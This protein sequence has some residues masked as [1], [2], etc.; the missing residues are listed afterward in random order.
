MLGLEKLKPVHKVTALT[1][2][3]SIVLIFAF[4]SFFYVN[5][6]SGY[7]SDILNG[8]YDRYLQLNRSGLDGDRGQPVVVDFDDATMRSLGDPVLVPPQAEALV[9]QRLAAQRPRLVF[10]DLDLTYLSGDEA[11]IVG[12]ALSQLAESGIPVLLARDVL[13]DTNGANGRYRASPLDALVAASPN[14]TWVTP[15]LWADE[16]DGVTRHFHVVSSAALHGR[17]TVLPSPALAVLL[18]D[19]TGSLPAAERAFADGLAGRATCMP[20]RA[21]PRWLVICTGRGNAAIDMQS[22]ARIAYRFGWDPGEALPAQTLLRH[23]DRFD[24]TVLRDRIVV[25]GSSA[26]GRDFA[27]TPLKRMPGLMIHANAMHA[28][29]TSRPDRGLSFWWGA[30]FVVPFATAVALFMVV[31][32]RWTPERFRS[33]LRTAIPFI[34]TMI[35]WAIFQL[36]DAPAIAVGLFPVAFMLFAVIALAERWFE[37]LFIPPP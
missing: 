15:M 13:P 35:F 27:H 2:L 21:P 31:V 37:R 32:I 19:V 34:L 18:F 5:R 28:W 20:D 1:V 22:P 6:D 8:V 10:F 9:L 26:G 17:Q 24:Q 3:A 29:L 14:L 25:I 4:Y 16:N 12:Q 7:F 30:G 33:A 23:A 36:L 11:R